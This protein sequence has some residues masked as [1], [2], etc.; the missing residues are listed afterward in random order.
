MTRVWLG[1]ESPQGL[2]D[3]PRSLVGIQGSARFRTTEDDGV[4]GLKDILREIAPPLRIS[5]PSMC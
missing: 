4:S 3:P 5:G 1:L 2:E